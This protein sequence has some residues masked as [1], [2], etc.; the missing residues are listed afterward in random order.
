MDT[1][2]NTLRAAKG[3]RAE[4]SHE[5]I[6]EWLKREIE[7]LKMNFMRCCY[8]HHRSAA[9]GIRYCSGI[10]LKLIKRLSRFSARIQSIRHI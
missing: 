10:R 1:P 9:F 7:A 2:Y 5:V 3:R 8:H 4:K 6:P